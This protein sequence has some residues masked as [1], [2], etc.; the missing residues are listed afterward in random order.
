MTQEQPKPERIT[1]NY[2]I[3]TKC[4]KACD[5]W[6]PQNIYTGQTR[7]IQSVCCL[8]PVR[9]QAAKE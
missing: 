9:V 4:G 3:C 5:A 7:A 2:Y 1:T 6:P 8:V